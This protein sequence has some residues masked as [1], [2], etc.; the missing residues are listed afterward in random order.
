MQMDALSEIIHNNY[1]VP[2]RKVKMLLLLSIKRTGQRKTTD[3]MKRLKIIWRLRS[4][5][6]SVMI[7][8]S[9]LEKHD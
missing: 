6:K 3:G 9:W 8:E 4:R 7:R 2:R 1:M 5:K